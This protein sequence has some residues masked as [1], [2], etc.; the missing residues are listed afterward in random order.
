[1]QSPQWVP[2]RLQ[3][4]G[5]NLSGVWLAQG[6]TG[7]NIWSPSFALLRQDKMCQCQR[8]CL[9]TAAWPGWCINPSP[10]GAEGAFWG[11]CWL[12]GGTGGCCWDAQ[13]STMCYTLRVLVGFA[14]MA[15]ISQEL[16]FKLPGSLC[17]HVLLDCT[18]VPSIKNKCE[19][20]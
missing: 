13:G 18:V 10:E 11:S 20:T 16:M 12:Q 6:W 9:G 17:I 5:R 19:G 1:M 15:G 7:G 4:I 14:F 3:V 8:S 2:G